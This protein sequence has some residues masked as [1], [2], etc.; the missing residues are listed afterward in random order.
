YAKDHNVLFIAA[1]GN[2]H[3]GRG[4]DNDSDAKPGV[5]ASYPIDNIVSVAAIDDKGALG[6][7]SNWGMR[8]VHLAAP[9]VKVF[10]TMVG[11]KY[12]DKVIDMPQ[13]GIVANWDGT[14]MACPHVAGAAALYWS[15]HPE[16]TYTQVKQALLTSVKRTSNLNGKIMSGGQLDV[17]AL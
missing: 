12:N 2:G 11:N 3:Q 4:Y 15:K 13:L 5:P 14:S 17:H 8:T 1:A 9:G 7:F 16:Y 10:S 6:S